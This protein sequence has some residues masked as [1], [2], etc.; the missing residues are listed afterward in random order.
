MK[1]LLARAIQ[2]LPE[3]ERTVILL[4]YGEEML[5][6]DIGAVLKVTESRVS[7]IH[8]RAIYRLNRE[9]VLAN[10]GITR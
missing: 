2:K 8:S 1:E 6:R 9:L 7:Q 3:P 4:Y 10:G 5:L